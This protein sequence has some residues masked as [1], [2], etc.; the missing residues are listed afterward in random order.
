MKR[1]IPS[2]LSRRDFLRQLLGASALAATGLGSNVALAQTQLAPAAATPFRFAF[3]TDLHLMKDGSLRSAEGIATCLGEVEKLTPRPEFILVGGDLVNACRDLTVPE[4]EQR[5]DLFLKIWHDH[6]ALPA[7]WV[8][9]NHDLVGTS[10]PHPP[11]TDRHYAKGLFHDRFNLPRLFYTFDWKG[12]HFVV[13][14]DIALDPTNHYFAQL[15]AEE[16][17]FLQADLEAHRAT[18][19]I[20]CTHIPLLSAAPFSLAFAKQ[21]GMQAHSPRTLVCTNAGEVYA[22]FPRH[23]VRA[24]LCGHLHHY[25]RLEMNGVSFINSGA[26][27]GNY[28]K[29]PMLDCVE[30]FGVV[31]LPAQGLIAF[32]YRGYGWKA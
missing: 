5:L 9:G 32:D 15:A 28:W 11:L 30:G 18:P 31:D 20:L 22:D 3:L 14:D 27:C 12:W 7:H 24:V 2:P 6:T 25:E 8:F 19:T 17:P 26:V 16:F 23:D 29:G 4:A 13:L 21:S 10:L 1:I